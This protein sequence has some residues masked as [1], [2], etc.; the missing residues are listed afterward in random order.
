MMPGVRAF[1]RERSIDSARVHARRI[2]LNHEGGKL[3]EL[4]RGR[5]SIPY[6]LRS[7]VRALTPLV[8]SQ[9]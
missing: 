9:L 8:A 6:I 4:T 3:D 5:G 2:T 1:A 7:R